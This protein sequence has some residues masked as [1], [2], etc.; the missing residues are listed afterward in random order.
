M[1]IGAVECVLKAEAIVGES[2]V[3]CAGNRFSTGWTSPVR[4]SIASIRPVACNDTFHLPQPVTCVALR[5]AAGCWRLCAR[6][7]RSSIRGPRSLRVLDRVEEDKPDNRFNGGKCDRQGRFWAGTMNGNHWD[8]PSGSLY[9]L[10]ADLRV[11]CEQ[12]GCVCANGL[13]WSP[14][15]RVMYF[16]ESFA[17]GIF[18]YDFEAATGRIANRRLFASV[19][20][21]FGRFPGRPDRRCRG[22]RVERS[23]RGGT[24]GALQPGRQHRPRGATSRAPPLRLR[25]R[26]GET[27]R[28]VRDDGQGNHDGRPDCQGAVVRK[29]FRRHPG[30]VGSRQ[31]ASG[32][33]GRYR[34][35]GL[36]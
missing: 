9:R 23:Q 8:A 7:S 25:V 18:A 6:I 20:K 30:V 31:V 12:T 24:G 14:D 34:P 32:D 36:A 16:T 19:D 3:W 29:P 35:F 4:R 33:E 5:N 10:D 22:R 2:P 26:R 13:D 1:S 17:Y 11:T 28:P 15:G 21:K 27:R